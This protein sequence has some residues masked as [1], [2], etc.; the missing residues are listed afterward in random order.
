MPA[1]AV[2][3]DSPLQARHVARLLVVSGFSVDLVASDRIQPTDLIVLPDAADA[4][5]RVEKIGTAAGRVPGVPLLAT[6]PSNAGGRQLRRALQRG[7]DGIVFD[8]DVAT[9]LIPSAR[10]L[11]AGQLA[12]PQEVRRQLAPR[13]LSHREK[14]ILALVV[15]GRTNAEIAALL[16]V[17]ES[18]VKTHL[19][20]AFAKLDAGSRAEAAAL[21]LDPDAGYDLYLPA[22]R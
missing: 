5:D 9:A 19:S 2:V 12:V 16:F 21:V 18:T 15:R 14:E 7:A 3:F 20:S 17:A 8:D 11:L 6:M 1:A 22:V 4:A 13:A 10:A